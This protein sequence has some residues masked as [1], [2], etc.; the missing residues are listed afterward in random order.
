MLV[1]L[2]QLPADT[3]AALRAPADLPPGMAFQPVSMEAGLG[4]GDS[5]RLT[6]SLQMTEAVMTGD[7]ASW[8][9]AAAGDGAALI[10]EIGGVTARVGDAAALA[11]L[12]DRARG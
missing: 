7:A 10:V 4:E 6:A 11:Y 8:L 12:I 5:F 1:T 2:S 9:W 3:L